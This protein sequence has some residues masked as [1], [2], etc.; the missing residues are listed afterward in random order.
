[1]KYQE[2]K[3]I[4][5]Q[6]WCAKCDD[7]EDRQWCQDNVWEDGCDGCERKPVRYIL[8]PITTGHGGSADR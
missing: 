8:A 1:M 2:H 7:R 6:P 4:W 3:E 5:L